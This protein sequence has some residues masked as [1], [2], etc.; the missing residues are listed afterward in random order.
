MISP[1]GISIG[2]GVIAMELVVDEVEEKGGDVVGDADAGTL[3]VPV[4]I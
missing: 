3:G 4:D 2:W 1:G